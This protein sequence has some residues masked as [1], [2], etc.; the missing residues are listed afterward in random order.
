MAQDLY[1]M[2]MC[3]GVVWSRCLATTA[4]VRPCSLGTDRILV[5][6]LHCLRE[7][8]RPKL[9]LVRVRLL[10]C[11]RR[12]ALVRPRGCLRARRLSLFRARA[13]ASRIDLSSLRL[14]AHGLQQLLFLQ[15]QLKSGLLT[16]LLL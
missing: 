2:E 8:R 4:P 12:S 16:S 14:R 1:G 10:S 3:L 13:Y 15:S 7:Q 6:D 9:V 5:T 11:Q